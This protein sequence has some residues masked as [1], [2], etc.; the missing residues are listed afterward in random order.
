MMK[1]MKKNIIL[2]LLLLTGN[3]AAMAANKVYVEDFTATAGSEVEVSIC[4]NT[5]LTDIDL[6]EGVITF[7]SQ[8]LVVRIPASG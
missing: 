6:I 2:L 1:T 8:L 3:L 7:P 5:D 4:L